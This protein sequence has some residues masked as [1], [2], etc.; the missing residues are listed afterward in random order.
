MI[1]LFFDY[2]KY[3]KTYLRYGL[4]YEGEAWFANNYLWPF[5]KKGLYVD[6]GCYHPIKF[7]QTYKLYK[8]GWTGINLDISK[9]SIDLF[10]SFRPKDKNLNI[11]ISLKS[12][13]EDGYFNKKISTT[14]SLGQDYSNQSSK[15]KSFIRKIETK[16]INQIF[17]E[18]NISEVD[19]LKIDCEGMDLSII[20]TFNFEKY[21]V[22]FL[23]IELLYGDVGDFIKNKNNNIKSVHQLFFKSELYQFLKDNFE[24]I[25]HFGFAFLLANKKIYV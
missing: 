25:D 10:N 1:K 15:K 7:S 4:G 23:S 17:E 22:N 12:G 9:E 24:L 5:K 8:F 11:G 3:Y 2:I 21:K 20:K 19:F 6:I 13:I 18:N 14:N 16:T